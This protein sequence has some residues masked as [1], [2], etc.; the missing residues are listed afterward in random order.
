MTGTQEQWRGKEE[1]KTK[2]KQEKKGRKREKGMMEDGVNF[3][4][5]VQ[6]EGRKEKKKHSRKKSVRPCTH[7]SIHSEAFFHG[8]VRLSHREQEVI[9]KHTVAQSY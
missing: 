6:Q 4:I 1:E 3:S 9:L 2:K 5:R 8:R 7:F